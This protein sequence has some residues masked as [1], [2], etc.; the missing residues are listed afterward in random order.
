MTSEKVASMTN[1]VTRRSFVHAIAVVPAGLFWVRQAPRYDLVVRGAVVYDG[2]ALEGRELDIG[3]RG[4]RIAALGRRLAGT[5]TDEIDARGLVAAP[6][7]VDIHSHADGTLEDDPRLESV[8]RQGITTAVVGADGGSR[9][10]D[11]GGRTGMSDWFAEV[12][13]LAPGANIASMVGLGRVRQVVVGD[14]DRPATPEELARM[15]GLVEAA[16]ASGAVGA[17]AGLEYTPGGFASEA[18]LVALC[19]PLAR[20]RL[21]YS[22]HMRNEDDRLIEAV[23]ES[24]TVGRLA[25]CAV[26]LAHLK[27]SGPRNWGKLDLVLDRVDRARKAGRDVTFDRYPYIAYQ[28]GLTNLFPLWSRDGGTEGFLA[29]LD[30]PAL[31]ARLREAVEAKV[32]LLGGWDRV[33]VASVA[34]DADRAAEG[35]RMPDLDGPAGMYDRA[36]GLLRR[37]QGRVGM[38]GFAMSEENLERLLRHPQAMVS[39]D[40]GS[41][42]IEGPARRAHPHPRSLGTFPRVLGRYVRERKTLPLGEA[43]RKMTSAPAARLRLDRRGRVAQGWYADLAIFDPATVLDQATFEAPFAYPTGVEAVIVNGK[44]ALR[45]GQR[46]PGSGR[47]IGPG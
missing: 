20:R 21:P 34:V 3:I 5:G 45:G 29:R 38:V 15:V 6:G 17:S 26:H 40:G 47:A 46:G 13:R 22:P 2:L 36:A 11:R 41:V 23:D 35:K 37:N 18:E 43:I 4:D 12:D 39:S 14:D 44:V 32:E 7:F 30:D 27:T 16:L 8:V 42:A 33:L 19:R 9:I 31:D 1:P 24:L 10:P 25:G 28:T